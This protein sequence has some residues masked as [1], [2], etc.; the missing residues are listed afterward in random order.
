M[1]RHCF[2]GSHTV[3]RCIWTLKVILKRR[4]TA[5]R[6]RG[7]KNVG[8]DYWAE[9]SSLRRDL[10]F[11][12]LG[13]TD[14]PLSFDFDFPLTTGLPP[15][16]PQAPQ[17]L[18]AT[19][20]A[21]APTSI[22][23]G[24]EVT[25]APVT[26]ISPPIN[27]A[28]TTIEDPNPGVSTTSPSSTSFSSTTTVSTPSTSTHTTS[29]V[30][31]TEQPLVHSFTDRSSEPPPTTISTPASGSTLTPIPSPSAPLPNPTD[32]SLQVGSSDKPTE[33]GPVRGPS[34]ASL[35]SIKDQNH[36][37]GP[38]GFL[39]ESTSRARGW[40]PTRS[41]RSH[42]RAMSDD[43]PPAADAAAADQEY[44]ALLERQL[45][46][47]RARVKACR[48]CLTPPQR[49]KPTCGGGTAWREHRKRERQLRS[50]QRAQRREKRRRMKALQ[51]N[52]TTTTQPSTTTTE[53]EEDDNNPVQADVNSWFSESDARADNHRARQNHRMSTDFRRGFNQKI[54]RMDEALMQ[55]TDTQAAFCKEL[56]D[57]LGGRLEKRGQE[58]G[59]L[60][61][62]IA[63]LVRT[64]TMQINELEK[65]ASS[66]LFASQANIEK[67]IA[68]TQAIRDSQ[69]RAIQG[70]HRETFLP[71]AAAIATLLS[72]QASTATSMGV[73]LIT[74]VEMLQDIYLTYA[75]QQADNF[76]KVLEDVEMFASKHTNM[77]MRTKDHS[78]HLQVNTESF[79]RELQTRMNNVV[80]ELVLIRLQSQNFV[81]VSNNTHNDIFNSLNKTEA[82]V[83]NLSLGIRHRMQ[84]ANEKE[85]DFRKTFKMETNHISDKI[86]SGI[87]QTLA[88]NHASVSQIEDTELDTRVYVGSA[89]AAWN[90]LYQNQEAEL[91]EESDSLMNSLRSH[92]HHTQNV[93][94]D[95]RSAAETHEQVLEEQRMDFQRFVRKRQDA[96]DN[97][98]S[99]ITDWAM[100][101]SSEL[102]RRDE[103]LHRF[104][105]ED[106]QYT[107]VTV[108]EDTDGY[109]VSR[110]PD[111]SLVYQSSPAHA[112]HPPPNVTYQLDETVYS[113]G[114]A[115]STSHSSPKKP[116]LEKTIVTSVNSKQNSLK[117]SINLSRKENVS[118]NTI[119][120]IKSSIDHNETSTIGDKLVQTKVKTEEEEDQP[121]EDG[122]K[123]TEKYDVLE[124]QN[125]KIAD[126]F[127]DGQQ[128]EI[129][130]SHHSKTTRS[131]GSSLQEIETLND[132]G[133]KTT[134]ERSTR[135]SYG[136]N[137]TYTSPK[138]DDI[139]NTSSVMVTIDDEQPVKGVTRANETDKKGT[140]LKRRRGELKGSENRQNDGT[141]ETKGV[142]TCG[143]MTLGFSK[144]GQTT[145]LS[146]KE[147]TH[148]KF[149][150]DDDE[151]IK[152]LRKILREAQRTIEKFQMDFHIDDSFRKH[153]PPLRLWERLKSEEDIEEDIEPDEAENGP[154][155]GT[156]V[157]F[158]LNKTMNTSF[159]ST[160]N[161]HQDQ[162]IRHS[163]ATLAVSERHHKIRHQHHHKLHRH[164]EDTLLRPHNKTASTLERFSSNSASNTSTSS[165][166][167]QQE[168]S[169]TLGSIEL[170]ETFPDQNMSAVQTEDSNTSDTRD[171]KL[172]EDHHEEEGSSTL[173]TE[174][175][176][177]MQENATSTND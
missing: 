173:S 105:N 26:D 128:E 81:S 36:S 69:I 100:L 156:L 132:A 134:T 16:L 164:I 13:S 70:Y 67:S 102:R 160:A 35:R 59:A 99:A 177:Q 50:R 133:S 74:K 115:S 110:L 98:C 146:G 48:S 159:P 56:R 112:A 149:Y 1:A 127:G 53:E 73:E 63:A 66:Q 6:K 7:S 176:I 40:V 139:T 86:E 109:L 161:G 11:C 97:Q 153:K 23:V 89:V 108:H 96:L 76:Q 88:S 2:Q 12:Q 4:S 52:N 116:Q 22:T 65:V 39:G 71:A 136:E 79:I 106:L 131:E 72:D 154:L 83:D 93:L 166:E 29:E 111:G 126:V 155:N 103:D 90:E 20:A 95:L 42:D 27:T 24:T 169:P 172:S 9:V 80:K 45:R 43:A 82:A 140:V 157:P 75:T 129:D 168:S 25:G 165:T 21:P 171:I 34:W 148:E 37:R 5:R 150:D 15:P 144:D 18:V 10:L 119:V 174:E 135:G 122:W 147:A 162:I 170:L 30:S 92:T 78:N 143:G 87:S 58:L 60:S 94:A 118:N 44:V 107:T 163:N 125:N 3:R 19:T 141:Y 152:T 41:P 85:Q 33:K 54:S 130:F 77:I 113:T 104:L 32:P 137:L 17:P 57:N 55:F 121:V 31:T 47:L 14:L 175:N 61:D 62:Q 38:G 138:S 114:P 49:T 120:I 46:D 167:K 51:N 68:I 101:M 28:S 142:S 158:N 117:D 64:S 124:E 123:L 151:G 91:R 145:S 8:K 84:S